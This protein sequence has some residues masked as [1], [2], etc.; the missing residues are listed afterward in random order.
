MEC[1]FLPDPKLR[2][3]DDVVV[4]EFSGVRIV[5]GAASSRSLSHREG[6]SSRSEKISESYVTS[7]VH[8]GGLPHSE[9]ELEVASTLSLGLRVRSDDHRAKASPCSVEGDN[10]GPQ[11]PT[12][13]ELIRIN[14]SSSP[15]P[16]AFAGALTQ[17]NGMHGAYVKNSMR[18]AE[19]WNFCKS[20]N[21]FVALTV[22][23]ISPLF[24]GPKHVFR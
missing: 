5:D 7:A 13:L 18:N 10:S 17:I 14:K 8:G 2:K 15:S 1:I 23:K 9:L 22:T 19:L 3:T 4:S 16:I 12:E 21:L 11:K 24:R 20:P 6:Q